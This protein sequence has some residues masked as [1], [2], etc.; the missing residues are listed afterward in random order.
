M[1]IHIIQFTPVSVPDVCHKHLN[2]PVYYTVQTCFRIWWYT[3]P[4]IWSYTLY[5]SHIFQYMIIAITIE[6]GFYITHSQPVSSLLF[7][8]P[9]IWWTTQPGRWSCTLHSPH[10]FQYL[11]IDTT[12]ETI[13]CSIQSTPVSVPGDRHNHGD[14]YVQY[15]VHTCFSNW[16]LTQSGRWSCTLHITHYTT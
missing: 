9:C 16:W 8:S 10:L 13:M 7:Q 3:Q 6:I 4:L 11:L 14:D 15:A 2:E 12:M 1:A 5:S